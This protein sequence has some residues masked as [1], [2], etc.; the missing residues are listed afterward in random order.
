MGGGSDFASALDTGRTRECH[1]NERWTSLTVSGSQ[2][3]VHRGDPEPEMV[4]HA[5]TGTS[6]VAAPETGNK[7][8]SHRFR[9]CA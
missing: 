2:E 4:G 6:P 5:G 3:G 8:G 9:Y 7:I 1:Y